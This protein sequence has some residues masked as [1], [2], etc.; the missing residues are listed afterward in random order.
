[1][2]MGMIGL[3]KMG[4]NMALRL[5]RDG[6]RI[7]G[8]DPGEEARERTRAN[9]MVVEE[10]LEAV[11]KLLPAPRV[12]W[13]MVPASVVDATLSQLLPLLSAG[14]CVVDGGNA[15]YRDSMRRGRQAAEH[16]DVSFVDCGT[17]GGVWGLQN[18]YSLMVGGEASVVGS[19]EPLLQS[20]A[21]ARDEGWAHVGPVGAGHYCKMVH[22]GIEYGM[23]QAY[24]EGFA[25]LHGKKAFDLD[26]PQVA[27]VWQSGSVIRSWLLDL[28]AEALQDNPGLEGIAPYVEDSGEGR[29][30]VAE[31][32]ELDVPAPVITL[33]LLERLRSRQSN[34]Y[35]DRLLA[36]MRNGFG[37]HA[38][39][40]AANEDE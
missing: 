8:F 19:L 3:G 24:A 28:S 14:D 26:L 37:G 2:D 30:T 31:A 12:V 21:P 10:Q 34:S 25:L 15:W 11:V 20:L 13:L 40:A 17:S 39:R 5:H 1:M 22:N 16:H 7:V 4:A 9:G 35:S 6:H 29:W 33:A 36:A 18:G 32:I 27:K 23:M 38:L